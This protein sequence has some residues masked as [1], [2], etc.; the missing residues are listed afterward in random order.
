MIFS[1]IRTVTHLILFITLFFLLTAIGLNFY[2]IERNRP[3][4]IYSDFEKTL[5]KKEV[6]LNNLITELS[7]EYISGNDTISGQKTNL[8][9][10]CRK[11]GFVILLFKNDTLRYWT[12][13]A[14]TIDS[15]NSV[16]SSGLHFI[17]MGH[18]YYELMIHKTNQ[19]TVLGLLLIKS[20]YPYQN[21]YLVNGFQ[22]NFRIDNDVQIADEKGKFNIYS[23]DGVFLFSLGLND[24]MPLNN[25]QVFLLFIFYLA[26]LLCFVALL[27]QLYLKIEHIIRSRIL[28]MVLFV[29]DVIILRALLFYFRLPR[30]L[31]H[32]ELFSPQYYGSSVLLPSF[33]DLIVN[34]FI[35]LIIAYFIYAFLRVGAIK[36]KPV[37]FI[38][39]IISFALFLAIILL[40]Q[41]CV[42][43]CKGL[44]LDSSFSLNLNNILS[45]SLWSFLGLMVIATLLLAYLMI[46]Y[47]LNEF[48]YI[49]TEKITVYGLLMLT[50]LIAYGFVCYLI[51]QHCDVAFI[52]F[53]FILFMSF[54]FH[55]KR[56]ISIRSFY[57]VIFFLFLFSAIMTY[58]LHRLNDHKERE[59]RKLMAIKL[60]IDRDKVAEYQ[61]TSLQRSIMSDSALLNDL[62]P[63][64]MDPALEDQVTDYIVQTYFKD[65]RPSY[66][67][68][69]TLCNK[70]RNLQIQPDNIIVGCHDYFDHLITMYGEK[71]DSPNL[72]YLNEGSND[73]NYLGVI[74]LG[75]N[76]E[77]PAFPVDIYIELNSKYVPKALGYP[78]LLMDKKAYIFTDLSNYSFAIYKNG[79]LIRSVGKY[80]YSIFAPKTIQLKNGFE[81]FNDNGYNHLAYKVNND[82]L[83]IISI[84]NPMFLDIIAPFSYLLVFFGIYIVVFLFFINLK[85]R[86]KRSEFTFKTS[87]Q[88]AIMS[89]II[90]SFILFGVTSL[91]NIINLNEKKNRDIL[92]EKTHSVL[93]ELEHK[94]SGESSLDND[95]NDYLASLLS[96]FSVIYFSDINLYDPEGRLLASSRPEI[97][98]EGLLSD[99]MNSQ[100]FEVLAINQRTSYIHNEYIGR[101]NFL[102][103]Y[104]PFRNNQN[105]LIAYLNLPYFARQ[106]ELKQ[107]VSRFLIAYTNIYIILAMIAI[108]TALFISNYITLPLKV[109]REKLGRLSLGKGNEKIEWDR[110]DEIGQ[111]VEEY[112]RMID[113]L[114]ASAELLARSERESAWRE[115]AKQVAHEI[116]NPLTP[117]KLNIQYLQKAWD[118]KASDWDQRLKR[119]SQTLIQQIDNLSA[120]ATEFSD[121]AKM[122][123]TNLEK[124]ELTSIINDAIELYKDILPIDFSAEASIKNKSFVYADRKQLLRVFNNLIKNSVQAIKYPEEGKIE[125]IT[126]IKDDHFLIYVKDNGAGIAGDQIS[127]IFTPSFT[128][129][130]GGMGLGLAIV[131]NIIENSGGRIRFE[132]EEGVGTTFI[133]ELP[134][135]KE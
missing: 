74:T 8:R 101:Y 106:G 103:A 14:V 52:I 3:S 25:D 67:I 42:I 27:F 80:L 48:I 59:Q 133:I 7:A 19:V 66:N 92:S 61:F 35:L 10:I 126:A 95:L 20:N 108:F 63:A 76:H 33:G 75:R 117:M 51:T 114:A 62:V 79:E 53:L 37:K 135:Y 78:E 102:S 22:R 45:F 70:G 82:T 93:I 55:D 13:N 39:N 98:K 118:E 73:I 115:M 16:V 109:I 36:H 112:N 90:A 131:K 9:K 21:D 71:T 123:Q 100:A 5:F 97:F 132:S 38:R 122:P 31:Y 2:F 17:E 130:S 120:I 46:A 30:T 60:S 4:S 96:K 125:I 54:W 88:I 40:F 23:H 129:K 44:V 119:F 134:S 85:A 91:L 29:L 68:Q 28:M 94:L 124:V 99:R 89:L 107:E 34:A 57:S 64:L 11:Q 121:F 43:L 77:H 6:I 87:L 69:V 24:A 111:L 113:E 81:F 49:Y 15:V 72:Y 104:M 83:F 32:S 12:R 41:L 105:K 56:R 86:S 128:T 116:K 110:K 18:G 1:N 47:R 58:F 26:A 127:K 65:Y 50:A 84:E